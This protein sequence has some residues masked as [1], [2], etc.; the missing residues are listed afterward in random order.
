VLCPGVSCANVAFAEGLLPCFQCLTP[1]LVWSV[2]PGDYR[3]EIA[4]RAPKTHIAGEIFVS[5]SGVLRYCS[6]ALCT[7]SVSSSPFGP[8]LSVMR[9][10]IVFTP[11]SARQLLCGKATDDRRWCT[12]HLCRN[13]LVPVEV[14]S[15]PPSDASSSGVTYVTKARHKWF[16]RPVAPPVNFDMIGQFE[17]RSTVTR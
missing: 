2:L 3:D 12:P 4:Y 9:R 6:I 1:S 5:G 10:F 17:Y 11:I 13:D 7:V 16:L 14:N 15:G 8:V